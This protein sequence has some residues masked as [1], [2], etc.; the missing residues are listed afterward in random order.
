MGIHQH[1]DQIS[2]QSK[3]AV[4]RLISFK[5][6][7]SSRFLPLEYILTFEENWNICHQLKQQGIDVSKMAK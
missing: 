5:I 6:L 2:D 7:F 3:K 4:S 1:N